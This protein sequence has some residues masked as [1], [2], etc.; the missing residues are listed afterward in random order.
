[1]PYKAGVLQPPVESNNHRN[2]SVDPNPGYHSSLDVGEH[3]ESRTRLID[4]KHQTDVN[5]FAKNA[6]QTLNIK[7][8]KRTNQAFNSIMD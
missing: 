1:M 6:Q 8:S 4:D 2:N 5:I 3:Q 7:K